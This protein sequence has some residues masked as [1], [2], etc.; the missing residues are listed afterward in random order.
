[1]LSRD[2]VF[3]GHGGTNE[4]PQGAGEVVA[5]TRLQRLV[6]SLGQLYACTNQTPTVSVFHGYDRD[7]PF[8]QHQ[9]VSWLKNAAEIW[10][11]VC[12]PQFGFAPLDIL[13]SEPKK[14]TGGRNCD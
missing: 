6:S 10:Q 13:H 11:G 14:K 12:S 2:G 3:Y 8:R 7:L 5:S 4:V 9:S 1:M